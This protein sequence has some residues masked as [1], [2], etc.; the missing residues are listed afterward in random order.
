MEPIVVPAATPLAAELAPPA[1]PAAPVARR[2]GRRFGVKGS[3]ACPLTGPAYAEPLTSAITLVAPE[4]DAAATAGGRAATV[5]FG[6]DL[7]S[8]SGIA[9]RTSTRPRA[10][11]HSLRS[12]R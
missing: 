1:G 8:S 4:G 6:E 11:G 9:M 12:T 2:L 7:A 3:L 10:T 5:S